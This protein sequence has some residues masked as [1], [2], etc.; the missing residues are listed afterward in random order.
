M[1]RHGRKVPASFYERF[2]QDARAFANDVASGRLIS[3]LE[4]GYSDRAL[5]SGA[6]SHLAGLVDHASSSSSGPQITSQPY[7]GMRTSWWSTD[8]LNHVG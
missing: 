4:G 3:I 6:M 1:S 2:T 8:S 7:I 5:L